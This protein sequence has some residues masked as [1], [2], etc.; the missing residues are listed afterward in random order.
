MKEPI[1]DF[2]RVPERQLAIHTRLENWR[3]WVVVRPHGWQ[4]HPM[5]RNCKTPRQWDIDPHIPQSLDTLDALAIERAISTMP[6]KHRDAIRWAYVGQRDVLGMCR[7]LGLTKAGLCE[8][9][10]AARDMVKN[11]MAIIKGKPLA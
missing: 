10:E 11:R 8:F 5:W 2:A 6:V 9:V 1:V 7:A 3:R 4:T